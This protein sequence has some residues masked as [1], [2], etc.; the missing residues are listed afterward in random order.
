MKTVFIG[1]GSNLGDSLL[2]LQKAWKDLG[3]QPG[4]NLLGLSSPY[5]TEPVGMSSSRWFV[6]AAGTVRTSL[7]PEELL[8]CLMQIEKQYGRERTPGQREY[9]NRILDFDLLFYDRQVFTSDRL[10][11]PHPEMH[12]RLFVLYPLSEIAPDLLHPIYNRT[13]LELLSDRVND[14]KHS[15]VYKIS[16]P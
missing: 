7:A 3:K 10:V 1:L 6:N 16:W 11:I 9:Q 5:R 2:V 13:M 12:N 15:E 14:S 4:V 8:D